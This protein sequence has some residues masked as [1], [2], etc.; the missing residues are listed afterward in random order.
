MVIEN[1]IIGTSWVKGTQELSVLDFTIYMR[2]D[3]ILK[4]KKKIF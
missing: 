3:I 4:F 1:V 2:V